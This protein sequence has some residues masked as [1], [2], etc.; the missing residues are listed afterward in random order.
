M[1]QSGLLLGAV[2]CVLICVAGC[3]R[4]PE[5]TLEVEMRGESVVLKFDRDL[6]NA[7]NYVTVWDQD[8]RELLWQVLLNNHKQDQVLEVVYGNLGQVDEFWGK[9]KQRYPTDG[10]VP[11]P[12]PRGHSIYVSIRYQYDESF[13]AT[14]GNDRFTFTIANDG[15][16]TPAQRCPQDRSLVIETDNATTATLSQNIS[17]TTTSSQGDDNE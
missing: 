17:T 11:K 3:D 2:A 15:T 6:A 8:K 16:V 9:P 12:L 7:I 5:V 13:Y 10:V 4:T 14:M 1:R